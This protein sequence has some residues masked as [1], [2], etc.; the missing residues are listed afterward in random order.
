MNSKLVV[1]EIFY[2]VEKVFALIV[3]YYWWDWNLMEW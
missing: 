2:D 1:G 3:T